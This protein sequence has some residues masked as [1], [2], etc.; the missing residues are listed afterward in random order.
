MSKSPAFQFYPADFLSDENVVLMSN[1]E[2]GCYIK[3]MCYCW[4]EGSIPSDVN[5]IA[6]ICGEDDSAMA[7]LWLAISPCFAVAKNS[8]D[9]LVHPRLPALLEKMNVNNQIKARINRIST[10]NNWVIN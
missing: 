8:P 3:L 1:T 5:K 7:H 10:N 4:R 9:R 6:K 2:V